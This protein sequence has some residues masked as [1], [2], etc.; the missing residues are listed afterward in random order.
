VDKMN[1]S[2]SLKPAQGKIIK[3]VNH[4]PA[5]AD[6]NIQYLWFCPENGA[7]GENEQELIVNKVCHGR[8]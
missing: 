6:K 1:F 4:Y 5:N 3:K 7:I 2:D 8:Q